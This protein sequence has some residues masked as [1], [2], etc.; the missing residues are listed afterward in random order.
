MVLIFAH[1]MSPNPR[2][3]PHST[4]EPLTGSTSLNSSYIAR[5]RL[6][7]WRRAYLGK[8]SSF[9]SVVSLAWSKIS[10]I[11]DPTACSTGVLKVFM[12]GCGYPTK[13]DRQIVRW[14]RVENAGGL[15]MACPE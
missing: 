1:D 5:K 9:A 6:R 13:S 8:H 14:I 7:C 12:H 11:A 15:W 10:A 4:T 3:T 2:N